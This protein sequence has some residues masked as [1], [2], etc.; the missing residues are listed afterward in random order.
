[1]RPISIMLSGILLFIATMTP[2]QKPPVVLV[3]NSFLEYNLNARIAA[4]GGISTV[5]SILYPETGLFQNAALLSGGQRYFTVN[6]SAST[7]LRAFD[8]DYFGTEFNGSLA[9]NANNAAGIY[10]SYLN[11]GTMS[12]IDMT[13]PES[14]ASGKYYN[15]CAKLVYAHSFKKGISVGG[16]IKYC[17]S[18]FGN[19]DF[20][21][22]K[23][24]KNMTGFAVDLGFSYITSF[25]MAKGINLGL[26]AGVAAT[27][28]GPRLKYQYDTF[29][30]DM[31][32]PS[33]LRAG[34]LLSPE[35]MLPANFKLTVDLSYQAEKLMTPSQPVYYV[36]V[37]GGFVISKGKDPDVSAF[38]G[39][40]QSFYDSPSGFKGE[41][42]EIG[43]R[44]ASEIRFAWSDKLY[45][46]VRYGH[47]WQP[48]LPGYYSSGAGG[49]GLGL[50]GFSLDFFHVLDLPGS[51]AEIHRNYG[52][53]VG[54]RGNLSGKL[55]HF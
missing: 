4:T 18:D 41:I 20:G 6:A 39:I 16:A 29:D 25:S 28:L 12:F 36:D 33:T 26:H 51:S 17:R 10:L 14:N 38:R 53:S 48:M 11:H 27:D 21:D 42:D 2:G 43:H 15:L 45:F 37:D 3:T 30:W 31:F 5:S 46:A 40:Y 22:G 35:F 9:F 49:L 32:Q 1:M 55:F 8:K 7:F 44:A 19:P 13:N 47:T 54:F 24:I 34:L 52:F 23:T 50:Y